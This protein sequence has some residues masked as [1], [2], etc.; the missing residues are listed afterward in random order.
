MSPPRIWLCLGGVLAGAAVALALGVPLGTLVVV[1]A[2]LA[3]PVAMYLGMREMG[4]P[5][6]SEPAPMRS[7]TAVPGRGRTPQAR[8]RQ[9]PTARQEEEPDACKD[10]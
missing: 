8:E 7:E 10:A 9:R 6:E 5:Q 1:A 2:L 3:C 4:T